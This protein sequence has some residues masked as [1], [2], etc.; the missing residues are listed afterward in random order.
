MYFNHAFKKEFLAT[1]WRGKDN[2]D[3]ALFSNVISGGG[4]QALVNTG[5]IGLF[6][7]KDDIVGTDFDAFQ[8]LIASTDAAGAA[9]AAASKITAL[10][11]NEG[12]FIKQRSFRTS[13]SI[14]SN[15]GHGGYT[16]SWKSKMILPK[17]IN[18]MW[19]TQCESAQAQKIRIST[20]VAANKSCFKCA[21]TGTNNFLRIDVKGSPALRFLNHNVYRVI[22]TGGA[23]EGCH[24]DGALNPIYAMKQ[25]AIGICDDPQLSKFVQLT[26]FVYNDGS[27][28]AN[29]TIGANVCATVKTD[30]SLTTA[31]VLSTWTNTMIANFTLQAAY[32]DTEF[33]T[34]SFDT[35]DN[36]PT[37]ATFGE[38]LQL[39][40]NFLNE[41]G[42]QCWCS[43][44][45]GTTTVA[46][47]QVARKANGTPYGVIKGLIATDGYLQNPYNQGNK[48]SARF[49]EIE[50]SDKL[51]AAVDT[52]VTYGSYNLVHSVPRFHNPTGVFDNDQYH[53]KINM[54]CSDMFNGTPATQSATSLDRMFA[55]LETVSGVDF[56]VL[57][58]Y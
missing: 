28:G 36:N 17:Y 11:E 43:S 40:A 55:D 25:F 18:K 20:T 54:K 44:A 37:N 7:N 35:R 31:S 4:T 13:D 24:V 26:E 47:T 32:V 30:A 19:K 8:C 53:Y 23:C 46:T 5:D 6:A 22:D 29:V 45:D 34:C 15:P 16:E 10:S 58:D 33:G 56:E 51:Y 1:R 50:G 9:H 14:G 2:A 52:T 48:D 3:A 38:P 42:D 21:D 49:R 12:F 57:G 39:E 41:D 27:G